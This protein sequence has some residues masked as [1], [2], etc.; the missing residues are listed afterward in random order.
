MQTGTRDA[1]RTIAVL[2]LEYLKSVFGG[3][4]WQAAWA[5]DPEGADRRL[6]TVRVTPCD[7]PG[8]LAAVVGTD[9]FDLAEAEARAQ[10]LSM[11]TAAIKGRAKPHVAPEF[12]PSGRAMLSGA[13]FPGAL[14]KAWNVPSRNPNFAG[15]STELLRVAQ[16]LAARSSATVLSIWGP[17]GVGKTQLAVEY[18]YAYA[19]DYEVVWW[20]LADDQRAILDQFTKLAKALGIYPP[21][22]P[23]RLRIKVCDRLRD[24]RGWLLIFDNANSAQDIELW[25]PSGPLPTGVPGHAIV[26]TRRSGF[27]ALGRV[28]HLNVLDPEDATAM[29]RIRVPGLSLDTAGRIAEELERL[30]LAL[31]SLN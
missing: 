26:T 31:V 8:L 25:L 27:A 23:K 9:L 11:V 18:A 1:K 21:R 10:L 15:R 30:P 24:S 13:G 16:H 19:G 4:E 20:I 7:R 22:D 12:P 2:S 29:L 5:D 6:L 14:P 17:I 3:A 28:F